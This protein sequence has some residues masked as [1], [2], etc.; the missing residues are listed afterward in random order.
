MRTPDWTR[1]HHILGWKQKKA[2]Y[3]ENLIIKASENLAKKYFR[4][5]FLEFEYC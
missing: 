1:A 5:F 2:K 3:K 4:L